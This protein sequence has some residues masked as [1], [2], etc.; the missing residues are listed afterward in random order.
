MTAV[1]AGMRMMTK[2]IPSLSCN[3]T[4]GECMKTKKEFEM[5]SKSNM[6]IFESM[7]KVIGNSVTGRNRIPCSKNDNTTK[8]CS[9][10]PLANRYN[11]DYS[12]FNRCGS[13]GGGGSSTHS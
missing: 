4:I 10:G 12:V 9:L 3:G 6:K 13:N 5:D 8:N 2:T 7:K 11:R 1:V